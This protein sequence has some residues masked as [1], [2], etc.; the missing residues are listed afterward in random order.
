MPE[1]TLAETAIRWYDRHARDLPWRRPG[2]GAWAVLVSEVMLQ[3]TQVVRVLPAWHEWLARWPTP[4][5]LAADPPAEAIRMWGRLGYP[6]RA[7]RLHECAA[8]LVARHGGRVPEDLD[9]LLAL[10]GVGSY[11]ARAVAAFAY[12]QRVPVVDTNVRRLV[13]RAVA[14]APDAGPA[15]TAADLVATAELL[16]AA[17]RRAARASVAFMELGAL[18]CTARAPGCERCPLAARCA[19]RLSGA[20]LPSGPTRRPQRYEGTDRHVR[21]LLMAV[22]REAS[23]PVPR[24]RL[25]LVWADAMQRSRALSGLVAD[26]LVEPVENDPERF[27]LAGDAP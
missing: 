15:T 22:L 1:Q 18:V 8:A 19:W 14:G 25:D 4:A 6:R 27:V 24:A 2:V 13:A 7:L 5:A 11:T 12:G 10:P 26:G 9:A 23:G 3:Q 16:P 20:A 21:G 17:P